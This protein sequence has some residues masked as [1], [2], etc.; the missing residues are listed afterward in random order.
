[1]YSTIVLLPSTSV[2]SPAVTG[3]LISIVIGV[4]LGVVALSLLATGGSFTA[5]TVK[6]ML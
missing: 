4:S 1:M 6:V 3:L 2:S 5:V